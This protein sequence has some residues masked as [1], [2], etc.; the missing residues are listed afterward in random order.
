MKILITYFS[1]TGNTEKIA[2]A[3]KN[4]LRDQDVDVKTINETNPDEFINY[5]LVFIGSGV[6]ASRVHG[7]VVNLIKK[8]SKFPKNFIYFCTHASQK[9]YQ[10]PFEK[11][12]KILEK[13]KCTIIGEFD[14]VGENKAMSLE[15]RMAMIKRLPTKEQEKALKDIKLT[16]GHPDQ[17]DLDNAKKFAELIL[18]KF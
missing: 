6:Y 17:I 5:N 10:T 7:S 4:G 11:I 2:Q 12:A 3:I 13:N 16:E 1:Q 8:V 15:T 18:E 14:C 9:L